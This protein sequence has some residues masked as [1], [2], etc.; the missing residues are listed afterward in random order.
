MMCGLEWN[1]IIV[2]FL[3]GDFSR[4]VELDEL[5]AMSDVNSFCLSLKEKAK[6]MLDKSAFDRM[7]NRAYCYKC[8]SWRIDCNG[9]FNKSSRSRKNRGELVSI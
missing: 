5:Y 9:R 6:G 2:R 3:F 4:E 1:R 7:S 8:F